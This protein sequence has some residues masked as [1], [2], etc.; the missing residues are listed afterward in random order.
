MT[1]PPSSAKAVSGDASITFPHVGSFR[2]NDDGSGRSNAGYLYTSRPK[3]ISGTGG[4]VGT[5]GDYAKFC[6]MLLAGGVAPSGERLLGVKTIEF[7]VQSSV[8]IITHTSH[9]DSFTMNGT[10]YILNDRP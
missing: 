2:D 3:M 7:A 6:T 1:A 5:A 10:V 8:H 4:M 9:Y